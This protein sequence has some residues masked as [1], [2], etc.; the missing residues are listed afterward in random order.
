MIFVLKG[1]LL[2]CVAPVVN[3]GSVETAFDYM[4]RCR[5]VYKILY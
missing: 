3:C 1:A 5:S 2:L 4:L